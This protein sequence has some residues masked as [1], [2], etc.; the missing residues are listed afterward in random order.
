[1]SAAALVEAIRT[2]ADSLQCISLTESLVSGD[3][4]KA[5]AKC[6]NLRGILFEELEHMSG[7]TDAA[8]A[9]ILSASPNL[10]WI[11]CRDSM[12]GTKSWAALSKCP[13]IEVLWVDNTMDDAARCGKAVGDIAVIRFAIVT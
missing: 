6:P 12:F 4:L 3:M 7:V 11:F 2:C 9:A 13:K 1:M 8:L 5:W 10:V